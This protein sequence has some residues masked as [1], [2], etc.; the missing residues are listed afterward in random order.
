MGPYWLANEHIFH[1]IAIVAFSFEGRTL[2]L[3]LTLSQSIR[4]C[5]W[6]WHWKSTWKRIDI[7]IA[8]EKPSKRNIGIDIGIEN[9][10]SKKHWHWHWLPNLPL[11][12][13]AQHTYCDFQLPH[14]IPHFRR[15]VTEF[16][17]P[18]IVTRLPQS[19]I[20]LALF[21]RWWQQPNLHCFS[22]CC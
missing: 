17:T 19:D 2:A 16:F 20:S 12:M 11:L 5:H 7:G 13:S 10:T 1:I 22:Q 18:N 14:Y 4:H 15:N 6:H 8:I 3:L 21:F 9:G